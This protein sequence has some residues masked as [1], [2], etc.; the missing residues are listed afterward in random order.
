[1]PTHILGATLVQK[2]METTNS[3]FFRFHAK[4]LEVTTDS[5]TTPSV[6]QLNNKLSSCQNLRP[7]GLLSRNGKAFAQIWCSEHWVRLALLGHVAPCTNL[8]QYVRLYATGCRVFM[9]VRDI[10][11]A[12]FCINAVADRHLM[13]II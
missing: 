1:M 7:M 3:L 11:G 8:T 12:S 2:S 6:C 10:P 4:F 13:E 5:H 9:S